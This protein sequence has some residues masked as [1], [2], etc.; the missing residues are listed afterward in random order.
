MKPVIMLF[1]CLF[2]LLMLGASC[3]N[4]HATQE[5]A[6]VFP[7]FD[8]RY[9]LKRP[10]QTWEMPKDLKEISGLGLSTDGRFLLAVQDEKGI[11]FFLDKKTGEI[12]RKIEFW[13]DGD[14]EG[15]EM[16]GEDVY[17]AKSTGTLYRVGSGEGKKGELLE[18]FNFFLT[19]SNDVEGLAYDA[20]RHRLLLACKGM[21][22]EK[23]GE[24]PFQRAIYAFD[25]KTKVLD[26]IPAYLI[27]L[28]HVQAYLETGPAIR[29]LEKLLDYFSL[30]KSEFVFSPSGLAIHPQTGHLYITSSV[31]KLLMVLDSNGAI[32][33]IEKLDKDIFPQPEGICFDHDGTLY[34]SSEGDGGK[35]LV[36]RFDYR[37]E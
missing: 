32:L 18:K 4:G 29:K 17:V 35:G 9:D 25:L 30:D 2:L 37:V 1:S 26:S 33:H 5:T 24:L 20:P 19:S 36:H 14:Y 3:G 7:D 31:G 27:S 6:P 23:A 16:V 8:F 13:K 22:G 28:E 15:I 34:I 10:D 11:I 21:A 12:D